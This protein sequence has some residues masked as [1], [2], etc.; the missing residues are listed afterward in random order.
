M[1][2]PF[3]GKRTILIVPL[4]LLILAG[5]SVTGPATSS[6]QTNPQPV[7]S[8]TNHPRPAVKAKVSRKRSA[9]REFQ[10]QMG[11]PAHNAAIILVTAQATPTLAAT[12]TQQA[13]PS[14]ASLPSII[15]FI[16]NVSDGHAE[17]VRGIYVEGVMALR[18]V[19]QPQGDSAFI[20]GEDGTATQ[21]QDAAAF[22]VTGLLAHNFLS[23]RKFF[24]LNAGQ[25]L[26]IIYGDGHRQT[27]RISAIDDYQRL[28][29]NDLHSNFRE[30][31]S[32][33]ESSADEVFNKYYKGTPHVILQTC[34]EKGG[35][36]TWG[37]R[38]IRAEPI[39][40][41]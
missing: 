37:V 3:P 33:L 10:G 28:S 27:Y 25:T 1:A 40:G 11:E 29:A 8:E 7:P 20:S 24:N 18:I 2:F 9:A 16:R 36:W 22:G 12:P 15:N 26:S 41:N 17:R 23:G 35:E 31:K 19:Q 21:F 14:D 38:F 30:L 39:G 34:I 5:C 13:R 32:G 6:A 4:L